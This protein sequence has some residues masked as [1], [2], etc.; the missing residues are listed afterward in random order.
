MTKES[1]YGYTVAR[2]QLGR[3]FIV[4]VAACL[5]FFPM[6]GTLAYAQEA[7]KLGSLHPLSGPLEFEGTEAHQGVLIAV[8]E[9]NASG[10]IKS[11]GGAKVEVITDDNGAN[12]E[13]AT[14]QA[15]RMVQDGVAAFL[16]TMSSGVALAIQPI[17]ERNQVPF[18]ITAASDPEITERRLPYTFRH[19]ADVGR[20]VDGAIAALVGISKAS[21]KPI[22]RVAHLRLEISAYKSLTGLL[23]KKLPEEGM[24]LVAVASAPFS[25]TDFSTQITQLKQAKPDVLIIS[26]LLSQSLEIIKTMKTQEFRPPLSIGI[27]A[28][29][30]HPGFVKAFPV[31]SENIADVSYWYNA[32]TDTWKN[33]SKRY[34]DRFGSM[35][36][37][38]AAQGY[39][40]T[41]IVLDALERAGTTEGPALRDALA[42]TRLENH[43]LPQKG[44]ITFGAD[45]Q[46]SDIESPVTQLIGG[47]AKV[48]FPKESMEAGW[49][50]P[51]PLATYEIGSQ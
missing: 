31:E 26:A 41:A 37:T 43:L 51:D 50:F 5:A 4:F 15:T 10:G 44:P 27:A 9:I 45:G 24:E 13:K 28:A 2:R 33:F 3:I 35:P 21:G 46:N 38:H 48:V 18:V 12:P 19:H 36:T 40:A 32:S 20:N 14:K 17:S 16:G 11:M 6:G 22:K 47:E 7:V 8:D 49:V 34:Q 29:F 39:Q 1:I 25:A 23:E 30:A 42:A